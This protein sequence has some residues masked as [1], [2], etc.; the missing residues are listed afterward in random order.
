MFNAIEI[1]DPMQF[2]D[3]YLKLLTIL[4]AGANPE[5]AVQFRNAFIKAEAVFDTEFLNQNGKNYARKMQLISRLLAKFLVKARKP[6]YGIQMIARA[7]R[8]IRQSS[9]QVSSLNTQYAMLC[10]KSKCLQHALPLI[11]HPITSVLSGTNAIE[12]CTYNYYRGMIYMGLE[13]YLDAIECFR[14]VLS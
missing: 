10:L 5:N 14:K 8:V 7:I 11:E 13:R 9:E 3:L 2:T 12:I 4:L 6:M 1:V